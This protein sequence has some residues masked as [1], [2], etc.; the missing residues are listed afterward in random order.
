[1]P[2]VDDTVSGVML[3]VNDMASGVMPLVWMTR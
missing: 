2:R 3:R 1:M